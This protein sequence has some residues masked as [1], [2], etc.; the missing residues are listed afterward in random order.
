RLALVRSVSVR[1]AP[2]RLP[3]VRSPGARPPGPPP[4]LRREAAQARTGPLVAA[5]GSAGRPTRR[6]RPRERSRRPPTVASSSTARR[7]HAADAWA[8]TPAVRSRRR[9]RRSRRERAPRV[10][11][12]RAPRSAGTG[13]ARAGNRHSRGGGHRRLT[14]RGLPARARA[15]P[16]TARV[17]GETSG[18]KTLHRAL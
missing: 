14:A 10:E 11:P 13:L 18:R 16:R 8:T 7:G 4:G 1:L 12:G 15:A 17:A 2:A 5:R 9:G 6:A 3:S